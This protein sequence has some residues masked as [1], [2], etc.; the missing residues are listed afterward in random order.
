MASTLSF[1]AAAA[2]AAMAAR[3]AA[4]TAS[5]KTLLGTGDPLPI[6]AY[7]AASRHLPYSSSA[8]R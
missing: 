2:A 5:L 4:V 6:P 3:R 7:S 8:D 1:I